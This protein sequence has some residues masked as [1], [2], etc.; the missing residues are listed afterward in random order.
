MMSNL[1]HNL[2]DLVGYRVYKKKFI[3]KGCDCYLDIKR[4]SGNTIETL[5]DVGANIGQTALKMRQEFP[6]A[7]IYA[8]EPCS[9][10][11]TLLKQ[12]TSKDQQIISYQL[13][14]GSQKGIAKLGIN[15]DSVANS[16]LHFDR[17]QDCISYEDVLVETVDNIMEKEKLSQ[18]NLLKTDAEG[19][20]LEVLKG[21]QRALVKNQI[22]FIFTEATI[23]DEDV[24]RTNFF[25]IYDFLKQY[26]INLYAIYDLYYIEN[27]IKINYFNALFVSASFNGKIL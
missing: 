24:Q 11:Y 27:P 6:Q 9:N 15:E 26:N 5:F 8:F 23:R 3:P 17:N 4:L 22:Q 2:F 25:A 7:V 21:C 16:L 10:S 18:I 13:A 14:L 19:Y 12:N 1:I 20:D